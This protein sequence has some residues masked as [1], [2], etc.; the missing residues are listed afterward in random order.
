MEGNFVT[1]GDDY[2]DNHDHAQNNS[3][4]PI[5]RTSQSLSPTLSKQKDDSKRRKRKNKSKSNKNQQL[6]KKLPQNEH[7]NEHEHQDLTENN[8]SSSNNNSNNN[9]Q[10]TSTQTYDAISEPKQKPSIDKSYPMQNSKNS[11][12]KKSAKLNSAALENSHKTT[13]A[14]ITEAVL[15]HAQEPPPAMTL[16]HAYRSPRREALMRHKQND[17]DS[18]GTTDFRDHLKLKTS[19]STKSNLSINSDGPKSP[20]RSPQS[21]QNTEQLQFSSD[22]DAKV[23]LF[24]Y[25]SLRIVELINQHTKSGSLLAHGEI[26]IFQLHN[27]D[28]TYLSCGGK[29]FIYPLLPK[30]KV[31]R[32]SFNQFLLP[33]LNPERY[34]KI[35]VDCEDVS[36]LDCLEGVLKWNVQYINIS[37]DKSDK[38]DKLDIDDPRHQKHIKHQNDQNDKND[39]VYQSNSSKLVSR[40]TFST[41]KHLDLQP[42]ELSENLSG[43][44]VTVIPHFIGNDIPDSP[45]SAPISP[46][47][48]HSVPNTVPDYALSPAEQR[49]YAKAQNLLLKQPS[50]QSL[51]TNVACL[52]V[53]SGAEPSPFYLPK[54]SQS[55]SVTRNLESPYH[56]VTTSYQKTEQV[57]NDQSRNVNGNIDNSNSRHHHI[58][59][60]DEKS[61]SSMDSLLDEFDDT[62]A[63]TTKYPQTLSR[64]SRPVSRQ[65]SIVSIHNP[66]PVYSRGSYFYGQIGKDEEQ[67]ETDVEVEDE[68]M[69]FASLNERNRNTYQA[70]YLTANGVIVNNNNNNT[71][72][73]RNLN[74]NKNNNSTMSR[75]SSRSDLYCNESGWMEPNL[76]SRPSN[77]GQLHHYPHHHLHHLHQQQQQQQHSLSTHA[78][79]PR[80]ISNQ[81]INSAISGSNLGSI[82]RSV[83]GQ[84]NTRNKAYLQQNQQ[85]QNQQQQQQSVNSGRH[86]IWDS[87]RSVK[88]MSQAN[89]HRPVQP[90]LSSRRSAYLRGDTEKHQRSSVSV[91]GSIGRGRDTGEG[92]GRGGGVNASAKDVKLD[93]REIYRL[94]SSK[95]VNTNTTS[96]TTNTPP[97]KPSS[98]SLDDI[99]QK[100]RQVPKSSSFTSRLFGW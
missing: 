33:L 86:D 12:S 44:G 9:N 45:P 32:I 56:S 92:V 50:M 24:K 98:S 91:N 74:R 69:H 67:D 30:I 79:I 97:A 99:K 41:P 88:L 23:T 20:F 8:N 42:A 81:S 34:W 36:T 55:L 31:L 83:I 84:R 16:Q 53:N 77:Q 70:P 52:D 10:D 49:K 17:H 62:V 40:N 11:D 7:Q 21:L 90:P 27:G 19:K 39:Q 66:V 75:R 51:S 18:V 47:Q 68:E 85:Q 37:N 73:T 28:V 6:N 4:E 72:N 14:P 100:Q 43:I 48:T 82:Y 57:K 35:Y 89:Y 93:S 2:N 58:D 26:E 71:N 3:K 46:N 78:K 87:L 94:L 5:S 54:Q 15:P 61:E 38:S 59:R 22:I 60:I 29:L 80:S 64:Q 25:K 13:P 76:N 1:S 96:A 95:Q 63:R 65:Q